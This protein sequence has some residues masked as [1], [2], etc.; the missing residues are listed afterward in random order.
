MSIYKNNRHEYLY[1]NSKLQFISH[2]IARTKSYSK[3]EI[4][5]YDINALIEINF[6]LYST[7]RKQHRDGKDLKNTTIK[8][9]LLNKL[10]L[11]SML[12]SIR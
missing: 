2:G 11:N 8:Q 12:K 5:K 1:L 10:K 3:D 7:E 9:N 6:E 4:R